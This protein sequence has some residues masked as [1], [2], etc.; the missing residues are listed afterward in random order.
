[1]LYSI[2]IH[3]FV[4]VLTGCIF[5]VRVLL[6]LMAAVLLECGVIALTAGGAAALWSLTGLV[7]IQI[8]YLGGI[9]V[10]SILEKAGL[11]QPD[12]RVGRV[13]Q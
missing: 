10:R 5:R 9:Y 7:A 6:G 8:G 3:F 13:R 4:G 12:A 11:T 2:A 1:M